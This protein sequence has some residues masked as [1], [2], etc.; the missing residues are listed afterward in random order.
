LCYCIDVVFAFGL[1]LHPSKK[2]SLTATG[3][4]CWVSSEVGLVKTNGFPAGIFA[5]IHNPGADPLAVRLA[6]WALDRVAPFLTGRVQ[7][8]FRKN[9]SRASSYP[10]AKPLVKGTKHHCDSHREILYS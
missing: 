2:G 3:L 10:T 5:P 8:R 1:A 4:F 7:D 6:L 9:F